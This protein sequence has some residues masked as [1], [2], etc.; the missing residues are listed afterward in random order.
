ML[1]ITS[2]VLMSD[3]SNGQSI[4]TH[5]Q[6][7]HQKSNAIITEH[8]THENETPGMHKYDFAIPHNLNTSYRSIQPWNS[9]ED[10]DYLY[11][12]LPPAAHSSGASDFSASEPGSD[13]PDDYLEHSGDHPPSIHKEDEDLHGVDLPQIEPNGSYS[14]NSDNDVHTRCQNLNV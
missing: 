8:L 3:I 4:P 7:Y 13:D 9:S 10:E 12:D 1:N 5:Q 2:I 6:R 14:W 11:G